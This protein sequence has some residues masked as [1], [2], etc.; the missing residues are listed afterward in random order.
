MDVTCGVGWGLLFD[1]LTE[2]GR[3]TS[4]EQQ[5]NFMDAAEFFVGLVETE[6]RK[7]P[8]FPKDQFAGIFDRSQGIKLYEKWRRFYYV[9]WR[10]PYIETTLDGEQRPVS[11][12]V[13]LYNP[14]PVTDELREIFKELEIPEEEVPIDREC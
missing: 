3:D 12:E 4:E 6:E 9:R 1:Y 14:I 8:E 11:E 10:A 2:T 7:E 13:S 5:E